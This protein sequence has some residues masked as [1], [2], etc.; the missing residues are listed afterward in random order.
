MRY[1]FLTRPWRNDMRH[2][3]PKTKRRY[4]PAF[5]ILEQRLTPSVQ[6]TAVAAGD[7]TSHDAI[8]WTRALDPQ[9]PQAIDLIAEVSTNPTFN[10]ISGV[11]LGRT[12]PGQDYT[13]KIDATGLQ[14]GTHYYYRFL[15]GS[16]K[17]ARSAN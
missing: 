4:L 17:P 5:E 12:D 11:F 7:T 1:A 13:V 15:T 6:Y 2:G 9:Q 10:Q 8:L 3:G 16:A 14:G